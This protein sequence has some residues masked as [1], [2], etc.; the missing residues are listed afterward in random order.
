MAYVAMQICRLRA[1]LILASCTNICIYFFYLT[2]RVN[3]VFALLKALLLFVQIFSLASLA[4][5][6]RSCG[7]CFYTRQLI[8]NTKWLPCVCLSSRSCG[9]RDRIRALQLVLAHVSHI[10][11]T[12]A[13]SFL[14]NQFLSLSLDTSATDMFTPPPD[15]KEGNNST[16]AAGLRRPLG[17]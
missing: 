14:S 2:R 16:K 4:R 3:N 17:H 5:P 11:S 8:I 13:A 1:L 7:V 15:S 10:L 12:V 9:G 6:C